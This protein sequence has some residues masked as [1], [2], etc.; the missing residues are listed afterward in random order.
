MPPV[1]TNPLI[2]DRDVELLCDEVLGIDRLLALP[3]FADHDHDTFAQV[4]AASRELARGVL[5]PSYRALDTEPPRL[6]GGRVQVHSTMRE[7][8]RRL[9]DLGTISAPRPHAVGGAQVPLVVSSL[10]TAYLMAANLSAYGYVGLTQGAAH[11]LEEF[12]SDALRATYMAPMYRGEWTG[13]MALTEPQAGSSLAD[14][15]TIAEPHPDGSYRLRGAKIFISGGDHDLTPNI[16][17]MTLA[18]IAGAPVGMHG[19]SLFCVPAKRVEAGALVDNDVAVTGVI[20]KI[21]WRG[22]PSVALAYGERGDCRGWLVGE[23]HRGIRYMFQMMNEARLMVGLNGVATASVAYHE[24]VAY[25]RTRAQ[26]RPIGH[27]GRDAQ[28]PPVPIIEHADVRRMLLRQKAIVE[29]GLALLARVALYADL[30]RHATDEQERARSTLLLDLLT[31]IAKSFPAEY[32]FAANVLAVQVHG[33][34]GY[35]SEYM[36]EAWLRD[37]KL[38]SIHEGT[39]GI[40]AA[41]LLGRRAMAPGALHVLGAEIAACCVRA[42]AAGVDPSWI[43]A[44]ERATAGVGTLTAELGAR[45]ATDPAAMLLHAA[46]YLE[47]FSIVAISWQWLDLAAVAQAALAGPLPRGRE[48]PRTADYYRAKLAAAEYWLHTDLPRVD[49]LVTLCRSGEASYRDLDPEWL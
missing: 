9:V 27:S 31:P 41:D 12:G 32:G 14:V 19:V 7:L 17:H 8:Y 49:H 42:K 21:G 24:A 29:G 3:Y 43:A 44:V 46:D 1:A 48:A 47:L 26:G 13:T 11:L 34:Y 16:V 20:H 28:T 15:A 40:Q 10:A 35:T 25:A 4:I 23:P 36:P 22:L 18:R 6:V 38:N 39:T 2:D 37:Q 5:F 33:G 45:G 30:A